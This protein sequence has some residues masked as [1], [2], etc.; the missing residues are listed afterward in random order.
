MFVNAEHGLVNLNCYA[1]VCVH[2][3]PDNRWV[4]QAFTSV[5]SSWV[6]LADYDD[7]VQAWYSLC[8]LYSALEAGKS[9]WDPRE[10]GSFSDLWNKAKKA[11][12]TEVKKHTPISLHILDALKLKITG[13]REITIE[14]IR[15]S[16]DLSIKP[17]EKDA[18]EQKLAATL[19]SEDLFEWDIEWED[20]RE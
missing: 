3:T 1:S 4:L 5:E 11:L 20:V 17:S 16:R 12:S 9:V 14:I 8:D 6:V 15:G 18:V 13:L 10:V 7:K 2:Q 19:K